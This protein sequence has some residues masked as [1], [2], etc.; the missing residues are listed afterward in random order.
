MSEAKCILLVDDDDT[1]VMLTRLFLESMS[2]E[3]VHSSSNGLEA[4]QFIQE[5]CRTGMDGKKQCPDIVLLDLNMPVM[6]GY[7]F[8]EEYS[9]ASNL[10]KQNI[11]IVVVSSSD[12]K[13]DRDRI[14]D[15]DVS[16]YIVK[17]LT[18]EKLRP[19]LA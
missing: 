14:A 17:P 9:K 15:F 2:L 18:E 12:S 3:D 4:I 8:L 19:F 10:N 13:R 11:R 16:G 6:D 1:T 7:E 5:N